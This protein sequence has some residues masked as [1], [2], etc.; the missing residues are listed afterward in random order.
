MRHGFNDFSAFL[1]TNLDGIS[2][3]NDNSVTPNKNLRTTMRELIPL[4]ILLGGAASGFSQGQVSFQNFVIFQTPDPTGCNRLVYVDNIGGTGLSGTQ[5]VAE[6]YAGADANSLAPV[7]AS[8]SRFRG[9]TTSNKGKWATS[10]VFGPNDFVNLPAAWQNGQ[11][12]VLQVKVWNYGDG[13]GANGTFETAGG[14]K[15]QCPTFTYKIP[16]VGDT[17]VSDFFMEGCQAFAFTVP[18]P[19]VIALGILGITGLLLIRRRK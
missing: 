7:T 17:T 1:V 11:T 6:L 16:P 5:Y 14:G 4:L 2:N 18:E 15:G 9:T 8:L 19:S 12:I 13:S 10:G 3:D